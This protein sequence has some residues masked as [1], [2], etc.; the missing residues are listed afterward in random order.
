ML[1]G[2]SEPWT[3]ARRALCRAASDRMCQRNTP[4]LTSIMPRIRVRKT[5]STRAASAVVAPRRVGV[6]G[7]RRIVAPPALPLAD[8]PQDDR[9]LHGDVLGDPG[10]AG[11]GVERVAG[12]DLDTPQA[13]RL[14]DAA[15]RDGQLAGVEAGHPAHL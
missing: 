3:M 2:A 8:C 10:H 4:R 5:S 1:L 7:V 9:A 13:A 12:R 6:R 14:G 11:E 15:G